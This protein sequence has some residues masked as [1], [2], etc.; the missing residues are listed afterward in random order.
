[1]LKIDS[2]SKT[3]QKTSWIYLDTAAFQDFKVSL[4]LP[5]ACGDFARV[6]LDRRL[7]KNY[8]N[9]KFEFRLNCKQRLMFYKAQ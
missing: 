9:F 7:K 3:Q 6:Y 2:F 5:H 8:N 4:L 1:M